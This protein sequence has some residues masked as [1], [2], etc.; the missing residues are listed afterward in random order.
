M[1]CTAALANDAI[2]VAID[3]DMKSFPKRYG[4]S[5]GSPRYARLNLIWLGC[6]EVLAVERIK[7]AMT[8]IEHER[9]I[10]DEKVARRLWVEIGPHHIRTNR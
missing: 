2:L 3:P 8:L 10:S 6:N 7:Q 5:H 1:V 9:K 4:I